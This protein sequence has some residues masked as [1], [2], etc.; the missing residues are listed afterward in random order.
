MAVKPNA[1]DKVVDQTTY[2]AVLKPPESGFTAERL[3]KEKVGSV[4]PARRPSVKRLILDLILQLFSASEPETRNVKTPR[5]TRA[6]SVYC[7]NPYSP[8]RGG[9]VN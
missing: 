4:F 9:G 5:P 1:E 6:T 3:F 2:M 8:E 7:V